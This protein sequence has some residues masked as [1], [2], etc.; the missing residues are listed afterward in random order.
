MGPVHDSMRKELPSISKFQHHAI[1]VDS[2]QPVPWDDFRLARH[3][4]ASKTYNISLPLLDAFWSC[5][6]LCECQKEAVTSA[7]DRSRPSHEKSVR[8][9]CREQASRPPGQGQSG[10]VPGHR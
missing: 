8:G 6:S 5:R 1:V 7:V 2:R 3:P 10:L 9:G 4:P